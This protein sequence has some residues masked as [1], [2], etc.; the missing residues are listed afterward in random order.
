MVTVIRSSNCLA[1]AAMLLIA[2][3][4]MAVPIQ[5]GPPDFSWNLEDGSGSVA[6]WNTGGVDATIPGTE[7]IAFDWSTDTL[8]GH[9]FALEHN[10]GLASPVIF[11]PNVIPHGVGGGVW[12]SWSFAGWINPSSSAGSGDESLLFSWNDA[13]AGKGSLGDISITSGGVIGDQ[14]H[15]QDFNVWATQA[16]EYH[17]NANFNEVS[18]TVDEWHHFAFVSIN[19]GATM[20][21]YIDGVKTSKQS[22]FTPLFTF[23]GDF[24][25]MGNT[26]TTLAT[27]QFEGI[28]AKLELYSGP[29]ND[30]NVEWLSQPHLHHIPEPAGL[31]VL[32]LGSLL[33]LRRPRRG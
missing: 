24:W 22:V 21:V 9:G 30:D 26:S 3:G 27:D 28:W 17:Q 20:N 7:G 2:Q 16:N 4:A 1:A 19:H 32:G 23:A 8:M 13:G 31:A 11:G 14:Y 10:P 29:L 18:M 6:A 12:S 33:M 5:P 15:L 25:G